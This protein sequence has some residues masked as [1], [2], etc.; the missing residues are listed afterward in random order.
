MKHFPPEL[1]P[2][3]ST[4]QGCALLMLAALVFWALVF[5]FIYWF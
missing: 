1:P 3:I 4:E 2:R 5:L